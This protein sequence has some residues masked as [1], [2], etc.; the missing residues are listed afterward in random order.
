MITDTSTFTSDQQ[1]LWAILQE[2]HTDDEAAREGRIDA[3]LAQYEGQEQ[4]RADLLDCV[5]DY[6]VI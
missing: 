2:A 1:A 5:E 6:D 4:A 3:L